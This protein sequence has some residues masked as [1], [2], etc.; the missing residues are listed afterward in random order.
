MYCKEFNLFLSA[1][2]C[3]KRKPSEIKQRKAPK[4]RDSRVEETQDQRLDL[5]G[6]FSLIVAKNRRGK[7]HFFL[8]RISTKYGIWQAQAEENCRATE[9][10]LK[11]LWFLWQE[12]F[13]LVRKRLNAHKKLSV[14][15][16]KRWNDRFN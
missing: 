9:Q 5:D 8:N 1:D 13:A 14:K 3:L 4:S 10:S 12:N 11:F 15:E 7:C 6:L 16:C 2:I